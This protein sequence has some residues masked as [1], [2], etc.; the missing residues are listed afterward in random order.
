MPFSYSLVPG[1]PQHG[2]AGIRIGHKTVPPAP[3][4]I[5]SWACAQELIKVGVMHTTSRRRA[6]RQ[7]GTVPSVLDLMH[8]TQLQQVSQPRECSVLNGGHNQAPTSTTAGP[9]QS[10]IALCIVH[11]RCSVR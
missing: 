6:Q 3:E 9:V 5:L 7:D 1:Q 2:P 10:R 4:N 11:A 8:Q